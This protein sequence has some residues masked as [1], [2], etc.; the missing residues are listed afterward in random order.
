[1]AAV[2][3]TTTSCEPYTTHAGASYESY[4]LL[5]TTESWTTKQ[6]FLCETW[7][8]REIR[9]P[10]VSF[11]VDITS[12]LSVFQLYSFSSSTFA[13]FWNTPLGLVVISF[14]YIFIKKDLTARTRTVSLPSFFVV[15]TPFRV[16]RVMEM[17]ARRY[18]CSWMMD[19]PAR[20]HENFWQ[21]SWRSLNF[22]FR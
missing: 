1:M 11:I 20:A 18:V 19:H 16:V 13:I 5:Q 14:G 12:Y 9:I 3:F 4:I 10:I 6:P 7:T 17:D 15:G 21:H 22:L 2:H 8:R